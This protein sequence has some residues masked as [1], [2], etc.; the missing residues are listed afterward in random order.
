MELLHVCRELETY[1][2]P[3]PVQRCGYCEG[4]IYRKDHWFQCPTCGCLSTEWGGMFPITP[5]GE[6]GGACQEWIDECDLAS[7]MVEVL[8]RVHKR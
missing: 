8:R 3:I 6:R 2:L 4:T 1:S 5:S 7:K